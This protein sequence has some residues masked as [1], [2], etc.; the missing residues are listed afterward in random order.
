MQFQLLVSYHKNLPIGCSMD[1]GVVLS[2]SQ[3]SRPILSLPGCCNSRCQWWHDNAAPS[4][5]SMFGTSCW[6]S[7]LCFLH[8]RTEHLMCYI[9]HVV[10]QKVSNTRKDTQGWSLSTAMKVDSGASQH[11]KRKR[12]TKLLQ[13]SYCR[14]AQDVNRWLVLTLR[15]W[16]ND[17]K[18][19]F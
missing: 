10:L 11:C 15:E 14:K 18:D 7:L 5:Q 12:L 13:G 8:L 19:I 2:S 17:C 3:V 1:E 16:Y 6:T 9:T 4:Q